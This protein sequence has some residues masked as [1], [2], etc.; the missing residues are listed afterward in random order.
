MSRR[1]AL[2]LLVLLAAVGVVVGSGGHF[3]DGLQA[4]ER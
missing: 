2:A 1:R 4:A 3:R